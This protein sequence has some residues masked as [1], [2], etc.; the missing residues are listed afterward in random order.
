MQGEDDSNGWSWLDGFRR[1]YFG[2]TP[3]PDD[4]DSVPPEPNQ[5]G[6]AGPELE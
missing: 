1:W 2:G 4:L 3:G 5:D 6:E